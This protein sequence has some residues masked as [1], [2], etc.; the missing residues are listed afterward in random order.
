MAISREAR[1]LTRIWVQAQVRLCDINF[2]PMVV[3]KSGDPD[4]GAVM[5]RLLR[6]AGMSLLLRRHF[7]LDGKAEWVAVPDGQA[8]ENE[9]A[10]E[11][12][13]R[14]IKR[15]PDLWV[16]EVDDPKARYWPDRPID[17]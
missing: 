15:D 12:I 11:R 4:A 17:E 8:I 9:A 10:Q 16:I 5:V 6:E 13:D 7:D 1:L 14:E 3:V 2:I